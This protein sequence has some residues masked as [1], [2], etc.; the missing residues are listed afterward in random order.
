MK[1]LLTGSNGFLGKNFSKYLHKN[2]S[3]G[4]E[5]RYTTRET[6]DLNNQLGIDNY[7]MEYRPT[8]VV[9]LA[10]NANPRSSASMMQDNCVITE[11][12]LKGIGKL[13]YSPFFL[14]SS[15]VVVHGDSYPE[16]K[17]SS[18]YGLSKKVCEDLITLN[19]PAEKTCILR[20][21]AMVGE[22]LTHGLV[23]DII[24]KLRL[25]KIL[26]KPEIELFGNA[27]GSSK[28]YVLANSVAMILYSLSICKRAGTFTVSNNQCTVED[29]AKICMKVTG[30]QKDIKWLGEAVVAKGDNKIID[31]P[32]DETFWHYPT[33]EMC[34][35]LGIEIYWRQING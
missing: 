23:H 22:N 11:K 28:P 32:I 16:I 29:V 19:H 35:E 8:H 27:P 31:I 30:I 10:G 1:I 21:P 24:K 26:N 12:L 6:L 34:L 18:I 15:S 13:D 14:F 25:A 33:S 5:C 2:V 9:H 3:D 17:P 7:L 4:F 20:L